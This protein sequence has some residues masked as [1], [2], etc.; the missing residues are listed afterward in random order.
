MRPPGTPAS[1]RESS[2]SISAHGRRFLLFALSVVVVSTAFSTDFSVQYL[3]G[4]KFKLTERSDL[5]RY[6]NNR[7]VGLSFREVRGILE[8][9]AGPAGNLVQGDFYVFEETKRDSRHVARRI[10]QVVAVRFS[11][12]GDG[13]YEVPQQEAYPTLRSFPVFPVDPIE[14]GESWRAFGVRVVEPFRDG[15]FTRVRFYCEYRHQGRQFRQGKEYEVIRAQYAMRYKQGEDPY[16]DQRI[17]RISGKHVVTIYYD[18]E[19]R[20]PTFMSDQTEERY[21]LE[22]GQSIG[23]KGFILTWFD[24]IDMMDRSEMAEKVR[25]ELEEAGVEDVDVEERAEGVALTLNKIHFVADQAV[26]LPDEKPRLAALG[27]RPAECAG[28]QLPGGRT[29]GQDRDRREPVI[30]VGRAGEN[31]RGLPDRAGDKGRALHLR[32]TGRYRTGGCQRHRR[33]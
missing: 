15:V 23:F 1:T 22:E 11:L 16:G 12:R 2:L 31:D 14:A 3:P 18:P 33:E 6:E 27:R 30:P 25:Q 24:M 20:R 13:T 7:F 28:T 19:Q 21:E 32:G 8:V 5:R 26:V 17:K 29:H 9:S 10:D 4:D